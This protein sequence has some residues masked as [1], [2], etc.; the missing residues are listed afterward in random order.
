MNTWGY[1]PQVW[2]RALA[3]GS[4]V[5]M[6]RASRRANQTISYSELAG[7]IKSI[8]F[9]AEDT[10]FHD[11]LGQISEVE[12]QAGRGMLSV[13]VVHKN[14]DQMPGRGFFELGKALG[15]NVR[16]ELKFWTEEFSKVLDAH[17]S[18]GGAH[19]N[20]PGLEYLPFFPLGA[21]DKNRRITEIAARYL[22]AM[23]KISK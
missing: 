5:L 14:G 15:Y 17:G 19:L 11:L 6:D 16:D 21:I 20:A 12:S 2:R 1:E 18:K 13:L 9:N 3:E 23:S 7:Q 4:K 22:R 10:D 8:C